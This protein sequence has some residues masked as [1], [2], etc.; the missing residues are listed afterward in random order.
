[1]QSSKAH[2]YLHQQLFIFFAFYQDID[3]VDYL[4]DTVHLEGLN[5]FLNSMKELYIILVKQVQYIWV[6]SC[7][8][9]DTLEKLFVAVS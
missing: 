3:G 8:L 2:I 9:D 1:M 7:R 5:A 4:Q 6:L